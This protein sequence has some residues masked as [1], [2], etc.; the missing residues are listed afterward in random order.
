MSFSFYVYYRVADGSQALALERV[1]LL[2]RRVCREVGS[3]GRLLKKR[4]EPDL[5]ME[6]YDRVPDPAAFEVILDEAARDAAFDE[7]LS[8]GWSRRVEC[9]ED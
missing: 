1:G 8:S 2:Q 5:W 3:G 4:G 6:V 7:V 9:F